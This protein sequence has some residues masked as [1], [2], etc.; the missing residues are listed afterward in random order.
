M[1]LTR[2][3]LVKN[4]ISSTVSNINNRK[5]IKLKKRIVL[6]GMIH[7]IPDSFLVWLKQ[8]L[9]N[10]INQSYAI[11]R[12]GI[13]IDDDIENKLNELTDKENEVL[14]YVELVA[15]IKNQMCESMDLTY[16]YDD[17]GIRYPDNSIN[18]DIS[19]IDYIKLLAERL[20]K[21]NID[22]NEIIQLL[23]SV[24]DTELTTR[25]VETTSKLL[26]G[27]KSIE[28][29]TTKAHM[30]D[31]FRIANEIDVA[32]RDSIAAEKIDECSNENSN[33]YVH[34]GETHIQ[35][36]VDLLINKGWKLT[37]NIKIDTENPKQKTSVNINN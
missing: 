21:D 27:E 14:R 22:C 34:Y 13:Y 32:Y 37:K 2:C 19:I 12:E 9:R 8:D 25:L 29:M 17:D 24:T 11:L 18:I 5:K 15:D 31:F 1:E 35:G 23:T 33:I 36:I 7:E 6:Q 10:H 4:S 28:E 26:S 20:A 3:K 16:Q 30:I